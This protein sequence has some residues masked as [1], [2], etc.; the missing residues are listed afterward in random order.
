MPLYHGSLLKWG[1]FWAGIVLAVFLA[2][3]FFA[4]WRYYSVVFGV[5][6]WVSWLLILHFNSKRYERRHDRMSSR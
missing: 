1:L 2:T 6:W 5:V 4:R 3:E